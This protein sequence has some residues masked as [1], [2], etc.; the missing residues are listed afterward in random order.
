MK[1]TLLLLCAL[2]LLGVNAAW[3]ATT[4]YTVTQTNGTCYDAN[5]AVITSGFGK[6]FVSSDN[7][8]TFE[9][10]TNQINWGFKTDNGFRINQGNTTSIVTYTLTVP[11]EYNI[12]SYTFGAAPNGAN[13][14]AMDISV[15]SDMS[16][17]TTISK[18]GTTSFTKD[19][20]AAT[21]TFY[22]KHNDATPIDLTLSVEVEAPETPEAS[23]AVTWTSGK[24]FNESTGGNFSTGWFSFVSPFNGNVNSI[25]VNL[26]TNNTTGG[27]DG[28]RKTAFLAISSDLKSSTSNLT[29]ADFIA[30]SN[31]EC[32]TTDSKVTLNFDSGEL[33]GGVTYY[34]YFVTENNGS[35][36][37]KNQRY[38]VESGSGMS[39]GVVG[40]TTA[41]YTN[42]TIPLS[43]T[44]TL[45]GGGYFRIRGVV[46]T[47]GV[48]CYLCSNSTNEDKLWKSKE[49][50]SV[51]DSRYV[52]NASINNG[53]ILQN[54]YNLHYI[55]N[56][57]SATSSGADVNYLNATSEENAVAFTLS[58]RVDAGFGYV[59][60]KTQYNST[61][62]WLNNYTNSNNYVG[63]HNSSPFVGD[64]FLFI[65]LKKVTFTE[66]IAVNDGDAVSIIY[67]AVDGSD[68]FTLPSSKLYSINGA[69]AV[70]NTEAAA[71]IAAAGTSDITVTVSDNP[72]R[73]VTYTLNWSDGTQIMQITDVTAN[74]NAAAAEFLP[75]A[76]ATDCVTLS[77]SPETI[78][79]ETNEVVVTATWNG[80]FQL[81]DSYASAKWY[82]VGI[83]STY[84]SANHIWKYVSDGSTLVT[85]AV[86]TDAYYSLSDAN[87][88]AFTGNPYTGITIYNKEAGSNMTVTK[89]NDNSQAT[90]SASGSLF[91][92]QASSAA[93][94]TVAA[95]YACFLVKD[96]SYYLNCNASQGYKI[97]GWAGDTGTSGNDAG[98]TCWFL[99]AG[100]YYLNYIDGLA[101]SAPVGAVGTS[102]YFTTVANAT[103]AK[104]TLSSLRSTIASA[105]Y[106]D[107]ATLATV[108]NQLDPV[109][110]AGK[111]ALTGG[112]YQIINAFDAFVTQTG[113]RRRMIFNG[114]A[115]GWTKCSVTLQT[116]Q[117]PRLHQEP[118]GIHSIL[119]KDITTTTITCIRSVTI[120]VGGLQEV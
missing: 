66:A 112:Y 18:G 34:C 89:A 45:K 64:Q 14:N 116:L 115:I 92:P 41:N 62:T 53:V 76:M 49:V 36:T 70:T 100:Q 98:S 87:C 61:D 93:N 23:E 56:F 90:V 57:T 73:N 114:S 32:G 105:L 108:N 6:K 106:S 103:E 109:R 26:G 54:A 96:G 8:L 68:S 113:T 52:W 97:Y 63:C 31:N 88:F 118:H 78:T 24:N 65:Q 110:N 38:Y 5:D 111:I 51:S 60:L 47:D 69:A 11:S 83:H 20:N 79:S 12:V 9:S 4:T 1:R 119:L 81:S 27:I 94:K 55:S 21:A 35:Y 22:L 102:N 72:S 43:A 50:P 117:L 80:P 30:I 13:G 99:P 19:V 48:A 107:M 29:S 40:S 44:M 104:N 74:L 95:G 25:T 91:V 86:P 71:A 101:L 15:N 58:N 120:V 16:S 77:Y 59:T 3:A 10:G 2:V 37:L 39:L 33:A 7:V 28:G 17:A 85:D 42:Y 46:P 82:T 84:Q 67:L 75:S